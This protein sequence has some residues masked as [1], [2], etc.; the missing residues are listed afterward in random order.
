MKFI[1]K[2]TSGRYFEK[3]GG[4]LTRTILFISTNSLYEKLNRIYYV[5]QSKI[6]RKY[7]RKNIEQISH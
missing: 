3:G 1:I 4:I 7:T 2:T 5:I 6:H